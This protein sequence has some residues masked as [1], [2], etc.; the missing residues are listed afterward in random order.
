MRST[1]FFIPHEVLGVPLFGWGW[2]LGLVIV[3]AI[4]SA[5]VQH[6]AGRS[7]GEL[8]AGLSV[9]LLAG[10]VVAMVLPSVEQRWPDG[11]P[12]GLPIRGYGT[13]LLLGMLAGLA[14][15]NIRGR[16]LGISPDTVLGLAV[17]AVLGGIIGARIFFVVQKRE[18]F[19]GHGTQLLVEM[20]KFTEGGL[21]IYGG[22]IGGLLA[23][24][25]Y[26]YR[27]GLPLLPTS[28]LIVPGFLIGL[29][30]GRIGCLLHGC[31][32][33]GI[34]EDRLPSIQFPAG[35]LPYQAQL[36]SGQLLGLQLRDHKLPAIIQAVRPASP[37]QSVGIQPGDELR[38]IE[39]RPI[40]ADLSSKA[41][42]PPLSVDLVLDSGRRT[43]SPDDLPDRSLPV[44][45]AQ[46]YAAINAL[47]LSC[48]TW[49]MQP[50]VR[51][52]GMVFCGA[53][54]LYSL[55][56]LMEEW[57][58]SDESGQF[59]SQLTIAQWISIAGG[60]AAIMGLIYLLRQPP[61]RVWAWS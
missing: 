6:R 54:I 60:C 33:G 14:I 24:L 36:D 2:L 31:C 3:A 59:G 28:D 32:F 45:P 40:H 39:L 29:A 22:M 58:R 44:H 37:A 25:V 35:S 53:V 49:L 17:W 27:H 9:W 61:R 11:T 20:L 41:S 10:A 30:C 43:I 46:I 23:I 15:T 5:I 47:L 55:S 16:R 21:V 51:R 57:I 13:M 1:L 56:R 26:C 19:T 12:I 50:W 4:T 38:R 7:S 48:L 42:G 52:D 18:S 8:L 34:C